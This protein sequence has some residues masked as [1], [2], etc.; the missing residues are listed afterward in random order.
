MVGNGSNEKHERDIVEARHNRTDK[1]VR[2]I[3]DSCLVVLDSFQGLP[4]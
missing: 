3:L 4:A 2:R 1:S